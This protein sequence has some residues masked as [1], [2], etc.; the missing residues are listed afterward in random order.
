MKISNIFKYCCSPIYNR[1][2]SIT[3][4]MGEIKMRSILSAIMVISVLLLAGCEQGN[5][6]QSG[7]KSDDTMTIVTTLFPLYEF[8]EAVAGDKANVSLLLP[9]GVEP[10]TF[11]PR[12]SDIVKIDNADL[13]VYSGAGLEPWA[14]DLIE[15]TGNLELSLLDASSKVTLIESDDHGENDVHEGDEDP[16]EPM[17]TEPGSEEDHGEYD[18]HFWLSFDNDMKVVDA[19]ADTLSQ[20]DPANEGYYRANAE[21]YKQ[22]LADLDDEYRQGLS[23]CR[24]KE[25]ITGGHNAYAYLAESYGIGYLSAFGISPDSEPTPQAIKEIADLTKEHGIGYVLFEELVSPRMA[26]AIAEQ[27]GAKTMVL[28]PGHNLMKE[29]FDSGVTFISLM[30]ENLKT[31]RIALECE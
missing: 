26:E 27:A 5:M 13:F 16:I 23:S 6:Q 22:R 7:A 17:V 14:H 9:P 30:E 21:T 3:K 1:Y 19:I 28:N 8:S 31:L 4:K 25:F 10:H 11:E 20:K 24:Q 15:G 2:Q 29:E 18:P 12:P